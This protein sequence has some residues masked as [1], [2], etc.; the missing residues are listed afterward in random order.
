MRGLHLLLLLLLAIAIGIVEAVTLDARP[1]PAASKRAAHNGRNN[2]STDRKRHH[3]SGVRSSA[4]V[5]SS[6]SPSSSSA[7]AA[8]KCVKTHAQGEYINS[9]SYLTVAPTTP[10]HSRLWNLK[11]TEGR[12]TGNYP[13]PLSLNGTGIVRVNATGSVLVDAATGQG[14]ISIEW[15]QTN[16]SPERGV[17]LSGHFSAKSRDFDSSPRGHHYVPFQQGNG[18]AESIV[19]HGC[20]GQGER[21]FPQLKSK[22]STW[23]HVDIFHDGKIL[24]ENIWLHT[25]YTNRCRD[26][27]TNA[28][29]ADATHTSIY[30]PAKCWQGDVDDSKSEFIFVAARWCQSDPKHKKVHPQTDVDIVF[31]FTGIEDLGD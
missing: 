11:L 12:F 19:Q 30:D 10:P 26:Y 2:R 25:M 13:D 8:K 24:Y 14:D 31:S 21:G 15:Q 29:F 27:D 9:T 3:H 20:S 5:V 23:G 17:S 6:S 18:V 1:A 16:F 4:D 22:L 28:M 7:A